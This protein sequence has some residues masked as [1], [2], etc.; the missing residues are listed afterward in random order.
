[1]SILLGVVY[2]FYKIGGYEKTTI[3]RWVKKT[4]NTFLKNFEKKKKL[5]FPFKIEE[6]LDESLPIKIVI[7][8][9]NFYY[10]RIKR[11]GS[12]IL[13]LSSYILK[14]FNR[15]PPIVKDDLDKLKEDIIQE[16]IKNKWFK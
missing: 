9:E 15:D 2:C 10:K 8:D 16:C 14:K 4:K 3:I 1:M 13:Y 7:D 12:I 6:S 11:Y 5:K